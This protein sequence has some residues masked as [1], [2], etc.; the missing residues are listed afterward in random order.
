M[1]KNHIHLPSLSD[2]A[3]KSGERVI[4]TWESKPELK[5]GKSNPMLGHITKLTSADV[6]LSTAGEYANRKVSEG[7]F[8]ST[9]EV[10]TRKAG[11]R[12]GNT[13]IIENQGH[14]Y[15][16]LFLEGKPKTTYFLNQNEI[17]KQ[18]IVGLPVY[19]RNSNVK[20]LLV[21]AENVTFLS[22]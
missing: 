9:D 1:N 14:M 8:K 7:E 15:V 18:N 2:L 5:G 10:K 13:C 21:K 12:I 17:N 3:N 11:T 20:I 22:V 16:E 19:K 4:I 6:T